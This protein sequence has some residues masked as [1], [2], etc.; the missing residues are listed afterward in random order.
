MSHQPNCLSGR[1][2]A[3]SRALSLVTAPSFPY[4]RPGL[5][6]NIPPPAAA[7]SLGGMPT[8]DFVRDLRAHIGH[9][10]L[11]LSTAAGAVLDAEG[12]VLLVRRAD[13]GAWALPGGI[14][15]P[16]EQP[17]DA[18]VREVFEETG[19]VAVP[20]ALTSVSV[21]RPTT[22]PNGDQVQYLELT[23]RCRPAGGEARVND[24][25]SVEVGWYP[26]DSLP[27]LADTVLDLIAKATRGAPEAA[28]TWR[29]A[30]WQG[31]G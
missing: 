14:I 29:G 24:T 4:D 18:A 27:Q 23:F 17:A 21:S 19:V 7:G 1:S 13:N 16:A 15:D 28:F 25:E 26:L 20:E 30:D 8:P 10:M 9:Q 12:R 31:A 6:V 11:W 2:A 3:D 22:Y 5:H